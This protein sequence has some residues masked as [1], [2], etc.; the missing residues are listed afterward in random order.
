VARETAI[1]IDERAAAELFGHGEAVGAE[2]VVSGGSRRTV[3]AVV[4]HVS[5]RGPEQTSMPQIYVPA[6]TDRGGFNFLVRT[7]VPPEAVVPS[8]RGA[9]PGAATNGASAL[10]IRPLEDAF[11]NITADRRFNASVMSIFGVLAIVI[12]AAGIFGVLA[13]VVAQQTREMSLRVALGA[14]T[15]RIV[16]GVLAQAGRYLAA[17]L[18]IGLT[19]AWWAS[20]G[21]ATILFDVRP[22]D[23]VVYAT[24]AAVM[25]AVGL[26][27][28]L[29]PARRAARV[30]PR[31]VL[32]SE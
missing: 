19:V 21:I 6:R 24:V 2:V 10:Q 9:L 32:R 18:A 23:P 25:A 16:T 30:D 31:I 28:A 17:G 15:G 26:L 27:A 1:V 12:G 20:Q 8:I 22:G 29:V 4:R 11:R 5:L 3:V 13:S 7:S 14:T